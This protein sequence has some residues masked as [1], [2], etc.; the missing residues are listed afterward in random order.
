MQTWLP[1]IKEPE[2]KTNMYGW[3]PSPDDL[4]DNVQRIP[5]FLLHNHFF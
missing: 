3:L 1:P 2:E 4:P 5:S